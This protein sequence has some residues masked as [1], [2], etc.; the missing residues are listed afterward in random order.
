MGAKLALPQLLHFACGTVSY[1]VAPLISLA[2]NVGLH[3][4]NDVGRRLFR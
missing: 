2:G 1:L 3:P 4:G